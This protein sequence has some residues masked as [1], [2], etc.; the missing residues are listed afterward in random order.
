[1]K[2]PNGSKSELEEAGGQS[3]VTQV[4]EEEGVGAG[5]AEVEVE[6]GA[7]ADS[8]GVASGSLTTALALM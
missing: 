3:S 7:E 2:Q 8:D 4:V 5:V 6:D 1:M